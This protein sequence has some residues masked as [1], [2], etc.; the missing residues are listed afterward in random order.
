LV[1]ILLFKVETEVL[2]TGERHL[3]TTCFLTMIAIDQNRKPTPV[4]KV[5]VNDTEKN[6]LKPS[7]SK[8]NKEEN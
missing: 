7:K 5:I 1:S 2:F 6:L 8:D 3:T 4:V